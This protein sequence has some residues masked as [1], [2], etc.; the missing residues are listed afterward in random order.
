MWQHRAVA[1]P[2][3]ESFNLTN[4]SDPAW[5]KMAAVP[6]EDRKRVFRFAVYEADQASGELR[7]SGVRIR[8]PDQACQVLDA[9]LERPGE[10]VTREELRQRLWPADTFVDFD[11]SLNTVINKLR[12]ALGD[13]AGN[14][15]F[16]ETLARRGY[17]FL[18]PVQIVER[19]P[20]T[21]GVAAY[22]AVASEAVAVD[23][24]QR[25]LSQPT[26]PI[27]RRTFLTAAEDLPS[28]RSPYVRILFL[29][30]QLMYLSFYIVAL[31]RLPQLESVIEQ[32]FGP[33]AWIIAV[34]IIA[35]LVGLAIRLY[36]ISGVVFGIEDLG[37][38]F[39]K[40]FV[41][42]FLLDQVWALAPL[43]LAPQIGIGLALAA[44]AT[45]IYVPF[46]QRTL[47]LMG[48]RSPG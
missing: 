18:A 46:S 38:K 37:A 30:I 31:A 29:L 23:S 12:E 47:L 22:Q 41:P 17:R 28:V 10:I 13:S 27:T 15:R 20:A 40:L 45:L 8:L 9:L 33:S 14:P 43:L 34:A 5:V 44:T 2:G 42:I 39:R 6:V 48:K 3:V 24:S 11:H 26:L 1:E 36:L 32:T 7:K 25:D 19:S 35:A 4:R 16:I 21:Q